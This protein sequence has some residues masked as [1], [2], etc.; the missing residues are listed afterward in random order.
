MVASQG[1][2]AKLASFVP[3]VQT[4]ML[5]E[6]QLHDQL[7]DYTIISNEMEKFSCL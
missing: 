1:A 2:C 6:L 4:A 7:I 5:Q 3:C